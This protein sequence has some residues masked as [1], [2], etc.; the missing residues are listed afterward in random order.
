MKGNRQSSRSRLR[1]GQEFGLEKFFDPVL[2]CIGA[3]LPI[4]GTSFPESRVDG[5]VF[6]C[7]GFVR[8]FALHEDAFEKLDREFA[9]LLISQDRTIGREPRNYELMPSSFASIDEKKQAQS[10]SLVGVV[11]QP[12]GNLTAIRQGGVLNVLHNK[13]SAVVLLL[14]IFLHPERERDV[15]LRA[16]VGIDPIEQ[17]KDSTL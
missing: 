12:G 14:S 15:A 1:C 16:R 11:I 10:G 4:D 9:A 3:A 8:G 5:T 13:I 17:F 6:K 2:R 7:G